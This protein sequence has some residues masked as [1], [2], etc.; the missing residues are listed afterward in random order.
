MRPSTLTPPSKNHYSICMLLVSGF[1]NLAANAFIDPFRAANYI[2]GDALYRWDWVGLDQNV[3]TASNGLRS[4]VVS[5]YADHTDKYDFVVVNASWAP[6]KFN[7]P[8]LRDW[9]VNHSHQGSTT[10]GV[11]TGAFLLGY[12]GLLDGYR[13]TV[14][15]EHI[16]AFSELFPHT[17][18][19]EALYTLDRNRLSCCG[20]HAA[21]D[22]ALEIIRINHGVD[23]ANASARYIFHER[24]RSQA[25]TQLSRALEPVGYGV[26]DEVREAIMLMERNL[27]EPL[28]VAEIAQLTN[29]SQR[30]MERLFKNHTGI[31]PIRYYIDVRLDR[32]RGLLTQT[33]MTIVEIATACGFHSSESFSRAYRKR[34]NLSPTQDRSEGR[35]PFHFRSFP[36]HAGL[37]DEAIGKG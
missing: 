12:A 16:A 6:E 10:I 20:G 18:V 4:D 17:E 19:S 28:S 14:H 23:L 9:L 33:E 27:E 22:L 35:I 8:N 34:F 2:N 7:H 11:D 30:H 32:A 29:I 37:L 36:S 26:P 5:S 3:V 1:N 15:Y 31:S 24:L 21:S 25:E 13:V